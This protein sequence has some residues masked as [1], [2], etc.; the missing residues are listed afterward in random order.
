M[1]ASHCLSHPRVNNSKGC[2]LGSRKEFADNKN[3]IKEACHQELCLTTT[4]GVI[5][6]Q[7]RNVLLKLKEQFKCELSLKNESMNK[8]IQRIKEVKVLTV[9]SK[10]MMEMQTKTSKMV[11]IKIDIIQGSSN[12]RLSCCCFQIR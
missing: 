3:I 10:K 2:L 11:V 8:N 7:T 1:N 6:K 12:L 9:D 5:M 4:G